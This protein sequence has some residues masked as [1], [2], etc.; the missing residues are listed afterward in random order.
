MA[1]QLGLGLNMSMYQ[2]PIDSVRQTPG[3]LAFFDPDDRSSMWQ[4]VGASTPVSDIDGQP[5]ALWQDRCGNPA[6]YDLSVL[7]G[8]NINRAAY[9]T[10][11]NGVN[12]FPCVDFVAATLGGDCCLLNT[13]FA[14]TLTAYTV[15]FTGII[16]ETSPN[17]VAFS[18]AKNGTNPWQG[19]DGAIIQL[20]G[21]STT[22]NLEASSAQAN[23]LDTTLTIDNTTACLF[24]YTMDASTPGSGTRTGNL[25]VN[26]GA[27]SS[28]T[29][30][31]SNPAMTI[32]GFSVGDF[33]ATGGVPCRVKVRHLAIYNRKLNADQLNTVGL[34]LSCKSRIPYNQRF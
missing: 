31:S 20:Q 26:G 27:G 29:G 23:P 11:A 5:V 30:T 14:Q 13:S 9:R 4:N 25:Y 32:D 3:L 15:M 22:L 7:G 34:C 6:F 33:Y 1:M 10:A 24:T 28:D 21:A 19:T 2:P 18:M 17:L 8:L 12:G 16:Y